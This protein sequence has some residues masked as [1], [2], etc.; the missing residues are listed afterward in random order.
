M[1]LLGAEGP[2]LG[3]EEADVHLSRPLRDTC[4]SRRGHECV[5]LR[6]GG[7]GKRSVSRYTNVLFSP[8]IGG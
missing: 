5:A 6:R 3:E 2:V 7:G 4:L 1:E 8:L